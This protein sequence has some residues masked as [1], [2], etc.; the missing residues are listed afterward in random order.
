MS[1]SDDVSREMEE[2]GES[3]ILAEE[4]GESEIEELESAEDAESDVDGSASDSKSE[5]SSKP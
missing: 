5:T 3:E 1:T 4:F 2:Y